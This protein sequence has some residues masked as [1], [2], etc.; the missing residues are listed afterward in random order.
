MTQTGSGRQDGGR[1]REPSAQELEDAF[2]L[3]GR[4]VEYQGG[5]KAAR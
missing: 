1:G 3:A 2:Q 4:H 5:A